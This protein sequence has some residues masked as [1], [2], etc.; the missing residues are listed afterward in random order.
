MIADDGG[1]PLSGV[2]EGVSLSIRDGAAGVDATSDLRAEAR[3]DG[4]V[5]VGSRVARDADRAVLA[6]RKGASPVALR[7]RAMEIVPVAVPDEAF[8]AMTIGAGAAPSAGASAA[9][10]RTIAVA[11]NPLRGSARINLAVDGPV[12]IDAFDALGRHVAVVHNGVACGPVRFDAGA[13]APGVYVLRA[14]GDDGAL[15]QTTVT[16]R[17]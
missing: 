12:R 13:L 4:S 3:A 16:V 15:S 10:A 2:P 11:P 9:P 1:A 6:I 8:P 7:I 17:R 5:H 14:T